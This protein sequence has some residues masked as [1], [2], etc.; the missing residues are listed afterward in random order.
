MIRR[1]PRSTQSRSSAASDVYKR[2]LLNSF[3][4]RNHG[5]TLRP[6]WEPAEK[7]VMDAEDRRLL[8]TWTRAHNAPQNVAMRC[9][10]VL[11]AADGLANN[12]IAHALGI[13]RPTVLLWRARFAAR[14]PQALVEDAPG[15]G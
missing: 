11:L 1:P 4:I 15:R 14:G 3:T 7:L 2:Q 10:V 8:E 13:S 12:A 6:M 5:A 9:Q